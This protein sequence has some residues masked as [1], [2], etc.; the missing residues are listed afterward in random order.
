MD[1]NHRTICPV[2]RIPVL[3]GDDTC[4]YSKENLCDWPF[5][6]Y[7]TEEEIKQ[8]RRENERP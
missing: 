6:R 3:C 1:I 5:S 7:M 8:V 4:P 2:D